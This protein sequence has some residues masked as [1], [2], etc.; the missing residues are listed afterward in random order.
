MT[1]NEE[2]KYIITYQARDNSDVKQCAIKRRTVI[3][4]D[5]FKPVITLHLPNKNGDLKLIQWSKVD[6]KGNPAADPSR[7]PFLKDGPFMAEE[8]SQS[9][10]WLIA[11]AASAVAGVALL[12]MSAKRPVATSVPV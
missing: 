5:T 10:G 3:V 4:R 1:A 9:Q 2:G 11:A 7:N 6:K 8:G 12:T